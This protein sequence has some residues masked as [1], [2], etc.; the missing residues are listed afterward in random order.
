MYPFSTC[1]NNRNTLYCFP[2]KHRMPSTLKQ[3]VATLWCVIPNL[4]FYFYPLKRKWFALDMC[5]NVDD[6]FIWKG[7]KKLNIFFK[8]FLLQIV[9]GKIIW[10]SAKSRLSLFLLFVDSDQLPAKKINKCSMNS[11]LF[12]YYS[13]NFLLLLW[14]PLSKG[15]RGRGGGGKCSDN[16]KFW[17]LLKLKFHA[18]LHMFPA[19]SVVL[20]EVSLWFQ[21]KSI[22][23]TS[24]DGGNRLNFFSGILSSVL[25]IS[26]VYSR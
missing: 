12:I 8:I 9:L 6:D 16:L 3:E 24:D 11:C 13:N 15:R 14:F 26:F 10:M 22:F 4:F 18:T 19:T 7:E 21:Q 5:I 20:S 25:F 17:M 23:R 1:Q 2:G